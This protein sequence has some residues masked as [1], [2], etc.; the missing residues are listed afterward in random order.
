[1]DIVVAD[2]IEY[3]VVWPYRE[4]EPAPPRPVDTPNTRG[5]T[6]AARILIALKTCPMTS[7]QLRTACKCDGNYVGDTPRRLM[8]DG[9]VTF[10]A[11]KAAS[12]PTMRLYRLVRR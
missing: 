3:Q 1:M 8:A 2:G 4:W 10:E 12:R 11:V 6:V 9:L 5:E 7:T